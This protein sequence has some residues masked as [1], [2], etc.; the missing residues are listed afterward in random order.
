MWSRTVSFNIA[1]HLSFYSVFSDISFLCEATTTLTARDHLNKPSAQQR[2]ID[3][4]AIRAIP[5]ELKQEPVCDHWR[6]VV[7][8]K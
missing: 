1:Y 3:K 6:T 2:T 8:M 5:A 4:S 7:Q